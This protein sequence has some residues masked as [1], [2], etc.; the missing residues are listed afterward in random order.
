MMQ[1]MS[2]QSNEEKYSDSEAKQRF[3]QALLGS[4][5]VGH[6]SMKDMAQKNIQI[7]NSKKKPAKKAG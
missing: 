2:N 1:I 6:K 4:T 7:K 5:K 3:E